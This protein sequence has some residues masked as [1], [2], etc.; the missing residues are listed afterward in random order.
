MKEIASL[1]ICA[2]LAACASLPNSHYFAPEVS[3][4]V[5]ESGRPIQNA[6]V[7]L[8]SQFTNETQVALSDASGNFTVGPLTNY[9]YTIK[10][11]GDPVYGYALQ[12]IVEGRLVQAFSEGGAGDAPRKID[13][14]CELSSAVQVGRSQRYCSRSH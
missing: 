10:Q 12:I 3:G 14:T 9:Q 8:S 1:A 6:R 13:L 4:V 7:R 2:S 5:L 11:F